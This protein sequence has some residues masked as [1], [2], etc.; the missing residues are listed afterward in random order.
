M[1][2]PPCLARCDGA[3]FVQLRSEGDVLLQCALLLRLLV[4]SDAIR[5]S[6]A[7]WPLVCLLWENVISSHLPM[8]SLDHA[9]F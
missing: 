9:V 4:I 5:T 3:G 8:F 7:H 1:T 2:L 6:G